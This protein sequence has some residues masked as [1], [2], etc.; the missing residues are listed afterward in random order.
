MAKVWST[1]TESGTNVLDLN[2]ADAKTGESKTVIRETTKAWVFH[3]QQP[4]SKIN[5]SGLV[6]AQ[7]GNTSIITMLRASYY[8]R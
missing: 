8:A 2:F 3:R 5:R 4:G 1:G 6:N 7:A